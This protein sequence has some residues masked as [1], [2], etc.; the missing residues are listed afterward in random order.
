MAMRIANTSDGDF[1][2][3]RECMYYDEDHVELSCAAMLCERQKGTRE[4]TYVVWY[5][6]SK[7]PDSVPSRF[8]GFLCSFIF[9]NRS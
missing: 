1:D 9:V 3:L 2:R 6:V 8:F 7:D 5:M 4:A